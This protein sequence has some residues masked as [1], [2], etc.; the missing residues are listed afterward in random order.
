MNR[1]KL[2]RMS[3]IVLLSAACL[4]AQS[5]A[6]QPKQTVENA[7]RFLQI[8]LPGRPY[9]AASMRD[10]IDAEERRH[11]GRAYL[12]G[13]AV[14][15]NADPIARCKSRL[16]YKYPDNVELVVHLRG[17]NARERLTSFAPNLAGEL[18]NK[19]GVAWSEVLEAK[20][21]NTRV[22]IKFNGATAYAAIDAGAQSM[23]AR[24]AYAIEFLRVNCDKASGT[25]F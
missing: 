24:V 25:G 16:F 22:L 17:Q 19:D 11:G 7:Q 14:I 13:H 3:A 20:A 5:Q 10:L 6:D 9:Y 12:E 18:G 21:D 1:I 8:T 4:P 23:A 15:T 2:V